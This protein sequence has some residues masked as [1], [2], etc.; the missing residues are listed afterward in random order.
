MGT[1]TVMRLPAAL[2]NPFLAKTLVVMVWLV[3]C[4]LLVK[5]DILVPKIDNREALTLAQAKE[6][7][8]YGIWLQQKRIGT[9]IERYE[10]LEND[11]IRVRQ[12]ANFQV[13]IGGASE[14]IEM[15]LTGELSAAME[16]QSFAFRFSSAFYRMEASGRVE[17]KTLHLTLNT[18]QV[19]TTRTIA[20]TEPPQLPIN[21]RAQLLRQLPNPGDRGTITRFDPLTLTPKKAI[22]RYAGRDKLEVNHRIHNLYRFVETSDSAEVQYWLNDRGKTIKE[23]SAGG[24][25][26]LA[27]SEAQA[28]QQAASA[29]SLTGQTAIPEIPSQGLSPDGKS[30]WIS[31][32]LV[33]PANSG[34]QPDGGRQQLEGDRLT[35][36]REQPGQGA[37]ANRCGPDQFL[38]PSRFLP[39]DHAEIR[40]LAATI[41][42]NETNPRRQAR[43]LA[44]WVHGHIEPG[45]VLGIPDALTTLANRRGDSN[46]QA[47][48]LAALARSR[49][50]PA[51]VA[52]GVAFEQNRFV[53]RAWN[54]VCLE[55]QW[56]SLDTIMDQWPADLTHLRL[57][58]GELVEQLQVALLLDKIQLTVLD[59]SHDHPPA[60]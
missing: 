10:P 56:F 15:E 39:A 23:V 19:P 52:I 28:R 38:A 32:R 59:Q 44:T 16:L 36:R 49:A 41:V 47:A 3:L 46:G 40:S 25:V 35:L 50:I 8:Y 60:H 13:Q 27:E 45:P 51:A 24:F 4:G 21:R 5:R 53:Y 42:G 48:L 20:L 54:E 9:T 43:L 2:T 55:G 22:V 29:P 31:Y 7:Q 57:L 37:G 18:G 33:L 14:P 11:R 17:E 12:T 6:E 58:R 30:Q 34:L 26:L 1:E